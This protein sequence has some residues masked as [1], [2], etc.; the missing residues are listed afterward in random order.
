MP[1]E[2]NVG[3]NLEG[4]RVGERP[5]LVKAPPPAAD[6]SRRRVPG[7]FLIIS[8]SQLLEW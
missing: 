3:F 2:S 7:L 5:S 4:R 8:D 6:L 1:F